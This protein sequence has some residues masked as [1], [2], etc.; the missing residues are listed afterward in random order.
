MY[1]VEVYKA[2]KRTKTGERLV[3]KKDYDTNNLPMLERSVEDTWRKSEGFRYEIHETYVTRRNLMTGKE[4]KERYDLS[5]TC[6]VES[7]SYWSA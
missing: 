7:E 3:L 6:S 4:V 1:T 5:W 2:D